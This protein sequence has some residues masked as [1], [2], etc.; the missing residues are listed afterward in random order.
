[1]RLNRRD[2]LK[3]TAGLSA[4][5]LI[6]PNYE[7]R[8]RGDV[9]PLAI[10]QGPTNETS[11]Q[12]AIDLPKMSSVKYVL[13][14]DGKQIQEVKAYATFDRSSHPDRVDHVRFENLQV[15]IN[16]VMQVVNELGVVIDERGFKS[17]DTKK[18]NARVALLSCMSDQL[19][20]NIDE[21]WTA[22]E[23]SKPDHILLLG[24]N[25]YGDIAGVIHGPG[26]LWQRYM[27]AR[28]RLPFYHWYDL[29]PSIAI[30]DDHDFGKNNVLYYKYRDQSLA[31]FNAFY[32]Q[33][34]VAGYFETGN[35]VSSS[36]ELFGHRFIMLDGRYYRVSGA[37]LGEAQLDWMKTKIET[38]GK[39][40][41]ITMG[42]QIFGGYKT[43]NWSLEGAAHGDFT[44]MIESLKK[45]DQPTYF[46][47]G[48]VHFS[49]VMSIT[50]KEFGFQGFEITSSCMHSTPARSL[51]NNPRRSQA[52]LDNNFV[53][54]EMTPSGPGRTTC[55]GA[56][57]IRFESE[58]VF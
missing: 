31:S 4:A 21:M 7:L 26:F 16:Y 24:D 34:N 38:A 3:G 2:F 54:L 13:L 47:S 39:P 43:D 12:I 5:A 55:Y 46:G 9:R 45:A 40:L 56:T 8:L 28:R 51:Q 29:V 41:F 25:I 48:D 58:I 35:G 57:G 27:D 50:R 15:D 52:A 11:T 42:S 18:A 22:V 49:E 1:M 19:A 44:A 20:S 23:K 32:A 17:L 30:W 10:L 53:L 14:Q 37:I 6:D 36:F 33:E